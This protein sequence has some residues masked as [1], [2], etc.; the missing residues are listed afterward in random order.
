MSWKETLTA[1]LPLYGHRNW[2]VVTD[3]AYPAQSSPGIETI[4]SGADMEE[5]LQ[6]VF[7][8]LAASKHVRPIVYTDQ[9]LQFVPEER[10]PGVS[11]FRAQLKQLLHGQLVSVLPHEEIIGKLDQA[12]QTFRVLIIK[13]NMTAPYTSVFLQLDC[14][15][16]SAEAER[17]LRAAMD[18]SGTSAL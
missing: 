10:A 13:T 17:Q 3:A 14:G 2:I 16:W 8:S 4:V 12:G 15:Y 5:V 7:Q 6:Q 11:A 18:A 1:R 9:E